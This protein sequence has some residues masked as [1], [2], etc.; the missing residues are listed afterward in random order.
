MLTFF[1]KIVL[2]TSNFALNSKF[3]SYFDISLSKNLSIKPSN[4]DYML[5][6]H[7]PFCHT[8]CTYCGF[9]KYLYDE[10]LA[11]RYFENLRKEIKQTKELGFDFSTVYVGGGTTLINEDELLKTL[12]LCKTLFNI[13]EISCESDPNHIDA[14]SLK[15]FQGLIDRLSC[16]VQSFND[17]VLKKTNRYHKFGSSKELINKLEKAISILPIFSIDLIFNFP[18]QSEDELLYDL[19]VAKNLQANQI[20]T[21]PLMKSELSKKLITKSFGKN[22]KDRELEFYE[23]IQDF[24]KD[25]KQNN[26][27][28]FSLKKEELSDEYVSY[29]NDYLGLGSGAFSFI[30]NELLIN[31]FDLNE[32]EKLVNEGANA[33]ISK[34]SFKQKD[35]LRYNFLTKLFSTKL[36]IAKFNQNF[37]CD[38]EKDLS[39]EI[40][41]LK[42]ANFV[43]EKDGVLYL[44]K[45]GKYLFV[46]LMKEF[47]TNMDTVRAFFK[48]TNA[49]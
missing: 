7:V 29:H 15:N 47:Y 32:Y 41:A 19:Q 11:K 10:E 33:K 3:K 30:D 49:L 17:N 26:C 48:K 25:Y 22:L 12:Q 27:W 28:S 6:I 13:K 4:K 42:M 39:L 35:I 43:Y 18:T 46:T 38:L 34:I 23:L 37:A 45:Q 2:K 1:Q 21:Y 40:K 24:F 20:T 44:S 5:Y 16:G 36:D 9:H 14:E 31:A 8:F